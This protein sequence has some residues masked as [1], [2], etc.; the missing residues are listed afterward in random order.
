[1]ASWRCWGLIVKRVGTYGVLI[2]GLVLVGSVLWMLRDSADES[3]KPGEPTTSV[4]KTEM[5]A[6][7]VVLPS[8]D[9]VR[10]SPEGDTVIAGRAAPGAMVVIFDD[11]TELGR[12]KADDRG[13]WVFL[14]EK[15]LP[16]GT[17]RLSLTVFPDDDPAHALRS[18]A[19]VVL[20]VPEPGTG[21]VVAVQM[22][23]KGGVSRV[24][25]R[26]GD[27]SAAELSIAAVDYDHKGRVGVSGGAEPGAGIVVYLD[28]VELGQT[29]AIANGDW[30]VQVNISLS[31]GE[32]VLRADQ[33]DAKG[34]V[35]KRVEVVFR[36]DSAGDATMGGDI[37]VVVQPGNSL[38]RI[39][40]RIYGEGLAYTLIFEANRT[41]IRD[42]DLIYP[43][44]KFV[45]PKG[46][47][48]N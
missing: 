18:D 27:A 40:R 34:A 39:A 3:Q 25:Q 38:W 46:Q 44:Q 14:P 35:L 32:H 24:L 8:F 36:V 17:R 1:M 47:P 9:I 15:P 22:P 4:T 20:V 13:E 29:T 42:P 31:E 16:T 21:G 48:K 12:A 19:D 30:R 37:I 43:G 2:L 26:P 7:L 23:Q 5:P 41:Q 33:V 6:P 11:E 28:T 10:I 45:A